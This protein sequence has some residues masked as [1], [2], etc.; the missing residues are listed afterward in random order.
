MRCLAIF[1]ALLAGCNT[2]PAPVVI[3]HVAPFTGADKGIGEQA[4]NGISLAL[5]DDAEK[6]LG[7]PVAVR[8]ADSQGSLAVAEGQAVRLAS[9]NHAM[10]LL[11]GNEPAEASRLAKAGVPVF[12]PAGLREASASDLLIATGFTPVQR[13]KSLAELIKDKVHPKAV[14]YL[15]EP[16]DDANAA[17]AAFQDVWNTT[18]SP[19][20]ERHEFGDPKAEALRSW[21][22]KLPAETLPVIAAPAESLASL[23]TVFGERPLAFAGPEVLRQPLKDRMSPIY[24]VTAFGT[25]GKAA[26]FAKRY[27]TKFN[28]PA[29]PH[30]AI[31]YDDMRVALSLLKKYDLFKPGE[32]LAML[33]EQPGLSGTLTFS[34]TAVTRPAF[35]GVLTNGVFSAVK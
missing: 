20:P 10:M 28:K 18:K 5:E 35:A 3:G 9:V 8:H 31:A 14:V 12:S 13:G 21:I 22:E 23:A 11:G 16:S 17:L 15:I 25:D 6:T 2:P 33:K 27:E 29:E 19:S 1:L 30:A 34:K 26:E 32:S 7:R 4:M 24:L